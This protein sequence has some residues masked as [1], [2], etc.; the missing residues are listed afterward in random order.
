VTRSFD[1]FDGAFTAGVD[2]G[3]TAPAL[4]DEPVLGKMFGFADVAEAVERLAD[5][6]QGPLLAQVDERA[7]GDQVAER[8]GT[9]LVAETSGTRSSCLRQ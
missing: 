7:Q 5:G 1:Q 9:G 6:L 4:G 8:V 3:D 2:E